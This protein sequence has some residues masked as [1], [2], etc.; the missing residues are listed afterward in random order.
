MLRIAV[1][2]DSH[3]EVND[4]RWLADQMIKEYGPLD[5]FIHCGDG[6][7]DFEQIKKFLLK[8]NY[9]AQFWQVSGNC[10]F[11]PSLPDWNVIELENVRILITHGH[12]FHVKSELQLLDQFASEKGCAMALYGHTHI[13]NWEMRSV[14]LVN[15][16]SVRQGRAALI[17][18]SDGKYD[19]RLLEY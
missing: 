14:L 4:F 8:T 9:N 12:R 2:S 15:P 18:L 19:A 6:A 16:G 11:S 7:R 5:G 13:A 10:D 1:F 17:T 3:G